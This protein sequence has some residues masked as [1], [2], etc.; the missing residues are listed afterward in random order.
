M[1]TK[2][3]EF[4]K[5]FVGV[6]S[7]E[8]YLTNSQSEMIWQFIQKLLKEQLEERF[9]HLLEKQLRNKNKKIKSAIREIKSLV[10]A[11][12]YS[13]EAMELFI[14]IHGKKPDMVDE[15]AAI[16]I[17]ENILSDIIKGDK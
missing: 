9:E 12:K 1:K 4:E 6:G 16:N 3:K 7:C 15:H 17:V 13:K 14:K 10:S 11:Q 2:K 8:N 5:K